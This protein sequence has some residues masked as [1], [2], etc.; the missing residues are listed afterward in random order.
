MASFREQMQRLADNI[1]RTRNERKAFLDKNQKECT[2]K[3]RELKDQ[4]NQTRIELAQEAKA[5]SK[6]LGEFKRNN[7]KTVERTLRDLRTLRVKTARNARSALKQEI[8]RNRRDIVRMLRQNHSERMRAARQQDRS[9]AI[10]IQSVRSQVQRIK[11]ETKRMTKAWARD[12][13]EARQIWIRLQNSF[14]PSRESHIASRAVAAP[15]TSSVAAAV[16]AASVVPPLV[17]SVVQRASVL[18]VPPSLSA[19]GVS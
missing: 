16:N 10:T 12:R 13:N 15:V 1:A 8:V 18:P 9:S 3:R 14:G 17:D 19:C 2:R 11:S 6:Q 5:L 4:R 7:Q